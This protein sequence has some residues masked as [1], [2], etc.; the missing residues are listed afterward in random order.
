MGTMSTVMQHSSILRG[1]FSRARYRRES[2]GEFLGRERNLTSILTSSLLRDSADQYLYR[3][4]N[5]NYSSCLPNRRVASRFT[6]T[7]ATL[8]SFFIPLCIRRPVVALL[9]H[10]F[11]FL[12][13][14]VLGKNFRR[15]RASVSTFRVLSLRVARFR[16]LLVRASTISS[17]QLLCQFAGTRRVSIR[18]FSRTGT[19][20]SGNLQNLYS[21]SCP[22]VVR[23]PFYLS[24]TFTV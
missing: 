24:V 3:R 2:L 7:M 22:F 23:F 5:R 11:P 12:V 14:I 13:S 17:G 15:G 21:R 10:F 6:P 18:R 9:S 16:V 4:N 1:S 20:S 19:K 8:F